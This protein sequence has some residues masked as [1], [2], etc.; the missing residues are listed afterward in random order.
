MITEHDKQT[1]AA[2]GIAENDV[3]QQLGRF[4]SGFPFL[5]LKGAARPGDGIQVLDT[6]AIEQA[7]AR[8]YAYLANGGEVTKFVPAS[9]AASRMFK[10]LFAFVDGDT[11]TPAPGSDVEKLVKGIEKLAF[12]AELDAVVK[13]LYGKDVKQMLAEGDTR[14]VIA[15]IILPEGMNYG[16][17]PKGLLTFHAYSDGSTRTPLEEQMVEGVQTAK[18]ADGKVNLHFTVSG[19]HRQMFLDKIASVAPSLEKEH[20]VKINV[21]LSE[22]KPST[23]TIAVNADN[24][25]FRENDELVFR[26]GGHGALIQNLNDIDSEV[27]FIKNIDNVVPDN[28]RSATVVYKKVIAG[29][30]IQVHDRIALYMDMLEKGNYTSA[31]LDHMV[32]FMQN[33][34][35]ISDE[36]VSKMDQTELGLYLKHKFDRPL[37]VCG[38]VRNEGEPGGGPYI[39]RNSDGSYSPQILES[40]QIDMSNSDYVGMMKSATHFNP[41]DLVCYIRDC[42]GNKYDLTKYVDPDTGF[43]SSKSLHG[44]ELK[45]LELPGLWNGAMSDWNTVFVEVP[46]D[47]F[48]P[49]KTVNDLLRNSHQ[50]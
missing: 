41:V 40:S 22:Q 13:K 31:D 33:T 42:K 36:R 50:G 29:V 45:A 27:V 7:K 18:G 47:T 11:D 32:Q 38:M 23:D 37:R 34:L 19:N 48:N 20:G 4:E 21:S 26:P 28:F 5:E 30:L 17:L 6:E 24:T 10:S 39:A 3:K 25:P 16:N 35:C 43:I 9:G 46:I 14:K 8:W 49:V 2:K 15:A 1:L 12:Y 44:R